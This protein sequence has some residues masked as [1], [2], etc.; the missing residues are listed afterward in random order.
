MNKPVDHPY[1]EKVLALSTAHMPKEIPNFGKARTITHEYGFVVFVE[2][3][4]RPSIPE[5]PW[6]KDAWLQ[7]IMQLAR[8]NQCTLIL[9]DRDCNEDP[10][11][12]TWDW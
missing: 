12:E 9:F 5:T 1:I 2:Q 10:D 7:P 11:L 6:D 3:Y 4:T 8:D